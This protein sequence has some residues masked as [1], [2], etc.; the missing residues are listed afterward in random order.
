MD[1]DK[2]IE[3]KLLID[4]YKYEGQISWQIFGIFL[5]ANTVFISFLMRSVFG[6]SKLVEVF[7]NLGDFISSIIGM[8]LCILWLACRQ[9]NAGYHM[10]R[11]N[12]AKS[13]EDEKLKIF[14]GESDELAQGN[15]ININ[16]TPI[17]I[18]FPGNYIKTKNSATIVIGIFFIFYLS[19]FIIRGPFCF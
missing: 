15:Q 16:N 5:I 6:D 19:I 12:Q 13:L 4:L 3:Y 7:F 9:R 1:E 18:E 14:K 8:L 11:L 2:K 10:L 17:K